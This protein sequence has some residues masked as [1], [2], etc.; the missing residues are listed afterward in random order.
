[1]L[2][3]EKQNKEIDLALRSI[4]SSFETGEIKKMI[5]LSKLFPT[6]I[7]KG[8]GLNHSRYLAKLSKPENFTIKEVLRFS[9]LIGVSEQK[10]LD[11][12]L[13]ESIPQILTIEEERTYKASQKK[14]TIKP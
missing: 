10:V 11:V 3:S 13:K 1:M 14:A 8:L 5:E 4:K 12:I 7:I 2:K 9:R 6:K